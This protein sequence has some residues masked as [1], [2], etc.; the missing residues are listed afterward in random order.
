[1]V[2][3]RFDRSAAIAACG[4]FRVC[5]VAQPHARLRRQRRSTAPE[6]RR[7]GRSVRAAQAHAALHSRALASSPMRQCSRAAG[8]PGR[9]V[10]PVL[11]ARGRRVARNACDRPIALLGSPPRRRGVC[12]RSA[13]GNPPDLQSDVV[14][15]RY[16]DVC[17]VLA[18]APFVLV[19]NLPIAGYL[20]GA[21][22]WLLTRAGTGFIHARARRVGE[23][24]AQSRA[25]G[26]GHDGSRVAGGAGDHPGPRRGRQGRRDH[27]GRTGKRRSPFAS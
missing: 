17:L 13:T 8:T 1:M 16:L 10:G 12:G 3:R 7:E 21:G 6:R 5:R 27:G 19:G 22:A 18:T 14:T 20:I 2:Q 9:R 24:E 26:R 23:P 25:A 11:V 15:L 4:L